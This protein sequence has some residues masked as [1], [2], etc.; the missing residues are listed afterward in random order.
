MLYRLEDCRFHRLAGRHFLWNVMNIMS[1]MFKNV[2]VCMLCTRSVLKYLDFQ[3]KY[4]THFMFPPT[5]IMSLVREGSFGRAQCN[6]FFTR[7]MSSV[8]G[9]S[10]TGTVRYP[11]TTEA[12]LFP[13]FH[14]PKWS[15]A[16]LSPTRP[17]S[18]NGGSRPTVDLHSVDG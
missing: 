5:I 4:R 12:S 18:V 10:V 16:Y 1:D 9:G 3:S 11:W 14:L 6:R 8:E 15:C 2:P 17:V 13:P 7:K